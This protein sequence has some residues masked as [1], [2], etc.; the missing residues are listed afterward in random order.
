MVVA[1]SLAADPL[2]EARRR[3][4]RGGHVDV[5]AASLEYTELLQLF[6]PHLGPFPVAGYVPFKVQFIEKAPPIVRQVVPLLPLGGHPRPELGE[7]GPLLRNQTVPESSLVLLELLVSIAPAPLE[8]SR[9]S[10]LL[11]LGG[12][13]SRRQFPDEIELI[14]K[15]NAFLGQYLG[16]LPLPPPPPHTIIAIQLPLLLYPNPQRIVGRSGDDAVPVLSAERG[17]FLVPSRPFAIVPI[18]SLR[19]RRRI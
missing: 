1:V 3:G 18:R 13:G 8:Q 16:R 12:P 17:Q 6:V 19:L 11:L 10:L 7:F 9:N 4:V 2:G 15:V 5:S 14:E